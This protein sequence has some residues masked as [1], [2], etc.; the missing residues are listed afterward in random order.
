M[1]H[2]TTSGVALIP[3]LI[4]VFVGGCSSS[5]ESQGIPPTPPVAPVVQQT[6]PQMEFETRTDTIHTVRSNPG[7]VVQTENTEPLIRYMVQIGAFRDAHN[8]SRV[9]MNARERYHVPVVNDYEVTRGLYQIRLG[10]FESVES[11]QA[12]CARLQR[13]HPGE[14]KDSWVVQLKR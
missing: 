1:K 3:F 6:T 10:F 12:F 4:L 2:V 14:Y 11:A 5:P 9:Q 7:E 8:A 13:E